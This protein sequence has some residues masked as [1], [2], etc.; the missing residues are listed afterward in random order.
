MSTTTETRAA[1]A[2]ELYRMVT[3]A[4]LAAGDETMLTALLTTR[5]DGRWTLPVHGPAMVSRPVLDARVLA[6]LFLFDERIIWSTRSMATVKQTFD[7]LRAVI[8]GADALRLQVR[9]FRATKGEQAIELTDGRWL[10]FGVRTPSSLR[11]LSV[12]CHILDES[13]VAEPVDAH[14]PLTAASPNP[15]TILALTFA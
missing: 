14:W 15:Q 8:D 6:G 5:P 3:G 12:D 13:Q 11:G 7:R 4:P 2:V 1:A 9:R 10:K